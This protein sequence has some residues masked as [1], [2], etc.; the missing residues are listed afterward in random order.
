MAHR[1]MPKERSLRRQAPSRLRKTT[2]WIFCEG[3]T[4]AH[5]LREFKRGFAA[6]NVKIKTIHE[7]KDPLSVVNAAKEKLATLKTAETRRSKKP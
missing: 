2:F 3:A 4:E 6:A 5:Y 7:G 1:R